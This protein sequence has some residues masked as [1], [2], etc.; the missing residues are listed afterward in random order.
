MTSKDYHKAWREKLKETNP[1]KHQQRIR[2]NTEAA[3]RRR[4]MLMQNPETAALLREKIRE[5]NRKYYE[6]RKHGKIHL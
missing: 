5:R 4:Q 3:K 6:G 2:Q 1:E